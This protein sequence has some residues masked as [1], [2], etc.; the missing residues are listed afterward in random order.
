MQDKRL[1]GT[2]FSGKGEGR[3]YIEIYRDRLKERIGFSPYLGT[4]NLKVD[5]MPDLDYEIIRG[6]WDYGGV[7]IAPCKIRGMEAYIL[8]PE[9]TSYRNVLELVSS[10]NLR[11]ALELRDGEAVTLELK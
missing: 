10:T 11:K 2:V 3:K 7:K 5:R 4:L 6:F 9:K 1:T 8:V